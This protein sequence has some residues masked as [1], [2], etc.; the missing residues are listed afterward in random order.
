MKDMLFVVVGLFLLSTA[1][2]AAVAVADAETTREVH[3]AWAECE[4]AKP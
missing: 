1:Y 4:R 2:A 3:R